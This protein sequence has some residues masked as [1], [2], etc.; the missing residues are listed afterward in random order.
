MVD[1]LQ[2]R[3]ID[4]LFC[5]GGDGT[6]RGAHL[7]AAEIDRRELP[8]S[9]VGIPKT[10]DNDIKYVWRTFG[11]ATAVTEAA[12]VIDCA[13]TEA[14]SIAGG[15]GLVKLMGR[16]AGFIAAAASLANGQVDFALIPEV[17][18]RLDGD[19]GLLAKLERRLAKHKHA[20]IVVA[21]GA[22]QDLL[23]DETGGRDAS[24]N[25]RLGDIGPF[26]KE[27]IASHFTERGL[28]IG[29]KYLDPSY[30]IRS[31]PANS[32]DSVLSDQFARLAAHA[33]MAGKTD[34]LIGYWHNQFIHVPL[35]VSTGATKRLSPEG[36][37]WRAVLATT[38]QEKW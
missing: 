19:R 35:A 36:D 27:R 1:F 20:V 37:L 13:H 3:Q 23:D 29:V 33:A 32:V 24:G 9:V 11:Y 10:I 26:L 22:G 21:E 17:P 4:I 34:L 12:M 14:K 6:Q 8:I 15:V 7:I 31:V 16:E 5:V 30:H 28:P 38:R 25:R 18:L 2:D